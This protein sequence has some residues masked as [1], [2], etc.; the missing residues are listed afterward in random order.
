MADDKSKDLNPG[1][2][3]L[4]I[5]VVT[6][7]VVL[8][9]QSAPK[10]PVTSSGAVARG[11]VE[12]KRAAPSASEVEPPKA[13]GTEEIARRCDSAIGILKGR[14]ASGTGFLV[15]PGLLAT[16]SH[17]VSL[18]RIENIRVTFPAARRGPLRAELIFEDPHRDLALLT[19][20]T[21]L[22]PL[23]IDPSYQFRRG[24]EV[25]VIGNPGIGNKLVLENAVSRGVMSTTAVIEGQSFYQL[26]IAINPGNSG[27]PVIDSTGSVIGVATL[28]ATSLEAMAF[29]IPANDLLSA[30]D[31]VK[32]GH[33]EADT[34]LLMHR[35]RYVVDGLDVIGIAYSAL[36]G[37]AVTGMDRAL[38]LGIDPNLGIGQARQEMTQ[39]LPK[40]QAFITEDLY[41]EVNHVAG[42]K[43]LSVSIRDEMINIWSICMMMKASID[44]PK[45]TTDTYRASASVLR[46]QHRQLIK[47]LRAD[48]DLT[49]P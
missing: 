15:A 47:R 43:R 41:P 27:G 16:N 2:L 24:Q 35:A 38:A 30:I 33:P 45:G 36:L 25:T 21:D 17:V 42:D 20:P 37:N 44:D 29:C 11:T 22:S 3:F 34:A 9:L 49:R 1:W 46:D 14:H 48:L 28:K 5:A 8:Y 7:L 31:Q 10:P 40:L 18:E 26:S 23:Q 19:V 6:F 39:T 12:S 4:V 13:L 32:F